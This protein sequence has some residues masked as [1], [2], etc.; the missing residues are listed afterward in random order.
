MNRY[1]FKEEKQVQNW[2]LEVKKEMMMSLI[3]TTE[4]HVSVAE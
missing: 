1:F 3:I 2:L 4:S